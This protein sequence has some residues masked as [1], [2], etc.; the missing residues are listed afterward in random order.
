MSPTIEDAGDVS[1]I[2]H[3]VEQTPTM[4]YLLFTALYCPHEALQA[5]I[6]HPSLLDLKVR[7]IEAGVVWHPKMLSPDGRSPLLRRIHLSQFAS[8][9]SAHA[10]LISKWPANHEGRS[11]CAVAM[12]I[13]TLSTL[14][15]VIR[16][17]N[18]VGFPSCASV[19]GRGGYNF[20]VGWDKGDKDYQ[21]YSVREG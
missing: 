1:T 5:S 17:P 20:M 12:F 21:D 10:A 7:H 4:F 11:V 3:H 6:H 13:P 2:L 15:S 8:L 18:N 16:R 14:I 19:P 9:S